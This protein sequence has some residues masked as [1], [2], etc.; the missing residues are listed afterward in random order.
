MFLRV[1]F[2]CEKLDDSRFD[3]GLSL[4]MDTLTSYHMQ[5]TVCVY[6]SVRKGG[7]EGGR[8]GGRDIQLVGIQ[9]PH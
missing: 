6:M 8:E 9:L 7:R 3:P 1:V 4:A 2:V 5:N